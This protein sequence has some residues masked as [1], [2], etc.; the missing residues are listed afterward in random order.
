MQRFGSFSLVALMIVTVVGVFMVGCFGQPAVEPNP[1]TEQDPPTTTGDN[2]DPAEPGQ[3]PT[4]TPN[5]TDEPTSNGGTDEPGFD[6]DAVVGGVPEVVLD[7]TLAKTCLLNVGDQVPAGVLADPAGTQ[8]EIETQLGQKL[9]V[10][11]FW[12]TGRMS[13]LQLLKDFAP[14]E[15]NRSPRKA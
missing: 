1:G 9:T 3:D 10:V 2:G 13:S 11:F 4:E 15:L 5:G 12:E 14:V 6:G 8:C 7:A